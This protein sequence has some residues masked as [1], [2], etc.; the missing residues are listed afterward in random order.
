ME[1]QAG[2][3]LVTSR[4]PL[5]TPPQSLDAAYAGSPTSSAAALPEYSF[6]RAVEMN[7][8]TDMKMMKT[9]ISV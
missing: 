9:A 5:V 8:T 7:E 3:L 1:S 2:F 4:K 6:R